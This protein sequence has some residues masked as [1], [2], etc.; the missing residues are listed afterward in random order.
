TQRLNVIVNAVAMQVPSDQ[1]DKLKALPGV[2]GVYADELLHLDTDRSP[3]FIGAP[4]VWNKLGGQESAGD[5]VI[6]GVL[7]TGIWPE[8]PSFS[9]PDPSAKPYSPPAATSDGH[10][11]ACQFS[12][13]A[14]PGPAFTC[15][16]KLIGAQRFMN[17]YELVNAL[18]PGEF[19]TARDDDGHGTHTS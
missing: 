1:V 4:T 6:V 12:G 9:D 10:A 13:G 5:N 3:A 8:H 11:R 15:N 2:V 18:E 14:N 7:D 19:T 17:T 16:N